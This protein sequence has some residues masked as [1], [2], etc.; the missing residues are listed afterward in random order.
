M[1]QYSKNSD[2]G[3]NLMVKVYDLSKKLV[4]DYS[5]TSFLYSKLKRS[6]DIFGILIALPIIISLSLV[7]AVLVKI[8]IVAQGESV[9][10]TQERIGLNGRVFTI[11]KFRSMLVNGSDFTQVGDSRINKIGY[12]I[13]KYRLDELP[14]FWN[15][16]IGD[17]SLIGPRPEQVVYVNTYRKQIPNYDL[18]HKVRPGL[19]GWAQVMQGY[20]SD[21]DGTREKLQY[22]L[23]YLKNFGFKM[24]VVIIWKTILTILTGFG[25]R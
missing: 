2:G 12:I 14:Q 11:Y 20:T 21:T 19:T 1:L 18:R 16:L 7:T 6:C 3:G 13:R 10:F 25:A 5:K 23:Y 8:F 17:M 9:I 4:F 15:I 22:D 24:D